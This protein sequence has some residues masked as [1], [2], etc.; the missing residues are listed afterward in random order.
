MQCV[1]YRSK[2]KVDT[3]LFAEHQDTFARV[4][5]PLTDMLGAL[6]FVIAFDP[7]PRRALARAKSRGIIDSPI[8]KGYYL[9]L[10]PGDRPDT[11]L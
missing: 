2:R 4:P 11:V 9:Q 3:Y 10:P 8:A 6:E 5:Q 7:T 1:V